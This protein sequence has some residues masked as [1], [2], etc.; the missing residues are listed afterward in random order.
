[1]AVP[2]VT[3][4]TVSTGTPIQNS[5]PNLATQGETMVPY[6]ALLQTGSAVF[7]AGVAVVGFGGDLAPVILTKDSKIWFGA[8]TPGAGAMGP[9][10]KVVEN[11]LGPLKLDGTPTAKF[12]ITAIDASGATV[13]TDDSA[14]Q[15]FVLG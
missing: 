5:P 7:V 2:V 8:R 10:T 13:A 14:I 12:T 3:A 11:V 4:Y 15:W 9:L 1:M 6:V